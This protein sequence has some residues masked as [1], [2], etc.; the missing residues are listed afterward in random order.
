MAALDLAMIG[1]SSTIADRGDRRRVMVPG[2]LGSGLGLG[3]VS[4]CGEDHHLFLASLALW[5][6]STAFQ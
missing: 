5:S 2:L 1:P 6:L 4:V 3:A